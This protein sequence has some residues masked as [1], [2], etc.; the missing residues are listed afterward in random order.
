LALWWG[1]N[2]IRLCQNQGQSQAQ[3]KEKRVPEQKAGSASWLV[4]LV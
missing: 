1:K 4:P 2:Q 3:R